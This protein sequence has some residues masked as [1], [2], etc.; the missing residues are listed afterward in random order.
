M[1]FET[2]SLFMQLEVNNIALELNIELW[3]G[4]YTD[5]YIKTRCILSP[6]PQHSWMVVHR[7]T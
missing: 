3:I 2:S 7:D 6:F 1:G 5:I 4:N